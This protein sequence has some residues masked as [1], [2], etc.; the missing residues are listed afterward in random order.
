V[1]DGF[2][3]YD[4]T[5]KVIFLKVLLFLLMFDFSSRSITKN[6]SIFLFRKAISQEMKIMFSSGLNLKPLYLITDCFN[7]FNHI[8]N[9]VV[10]VVAKYDQSLRR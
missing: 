2:V 3:Y 7:C 5:R 9:F 10:I 8:H 4:F 6:V 1:L